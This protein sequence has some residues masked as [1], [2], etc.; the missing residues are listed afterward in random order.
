M[1]D[2]VREMHKL[3]PA[4]RASHGDHP[5]TSAGR[6]TR[7][8]AQTRAGAGQGTIVRQLDRD[9]PRLPCQGPARAGQIPALPDDRC[10]QRQGTRQAVVPARLLR[11][12][13]EGRAGTAPSP[14]SGRASRS[15]G[16]T[17]RRSS[18]RHQGRTRQR[19]ARSPRDGRS[20]PRPGPRAS[21]YPLAP[22]IL[23]ISANPVLLRERFPVCFRCRV[24]YDRASLPVRAG[25]GWSGQAAMVGVAQLVERQVVVLDV[26]GSSP[27]VHPRVS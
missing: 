21:R 14:T 11:Q 7:L 12:P 15:C 3:R 16:T 24:G 8:R 13:G 18:Y 19:H 5:G 17:A 26:V 20:A 23:A 10:L 1:P 2:L 9:R 6:G 27:I 4:D 25:A 22:A